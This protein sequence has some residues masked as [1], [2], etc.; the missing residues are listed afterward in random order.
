MRD[1]ALALHRDGKRPGFLNP[2]D[3]KAVLDGAIGMY[4]L[5]RNIA[6]EEVIAVQTTF[7]LH[8]KVFDS[9]KYWNRSTAVNDLPPSL[10]EL[11]RP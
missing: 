10:R 8:S 5:E 6:L 9:M 1:I 11:Y 3:G 2:S 4:W 7:L